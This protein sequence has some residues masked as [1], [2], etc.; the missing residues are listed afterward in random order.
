MSQ[1]LELEVGSW[2]DGGVCVARHEGRV[3][4]VSHTLPGERVLAK[5]TDQ[6]K[7]HWWADAVEVLE[8]SPD[9]REHFWPAAGPGGV[10][11]AALGHVAPA[12]ARRAKADLIRGH[13]KHLAGVAW[14]G[15]VEAVAVGEAGGAADGAEDTAEARY[16]T[17][18]RTRI[19]LHADDAGRPGMYGERS[20]RLVALDSMPL[21]VPAINGLGLFERA[22]P[23]GATLNV[24]APS[25]GEP[26]VLV[27]RPGRGRAVG[28]DVTEQVGEHRYVVAARGFWQMHV[29]APATLTEAVLQAAAP[30]PTDKVWDLYSGAGLFTLPL[31]QA[32]GPQGA[33]T[34]VE[35]N[36]L[37]VNRAST[38]IKAAGYPWARAVQAQ[39]P[40][41]V[42][43]LLEDASGAIAVLD[44]PR[45]GAG[46]AVMEALARAGIGRIC[47]VSCAPA[48]FARDLG[49]AQR[50]GYELRSLRA[51]DLFPATSHTEL[52][53]QIALPR[54]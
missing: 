28:P 26:V 47:Y 10:G 23:A 45:A 39:L 2:G 14:D 51:F 52:V 42:T 7:S 19:V 24:V 29:R 38:N 37:A 31:A 21:A 3:V 53:A 46:P 6:R 30:A 48:T 43:R 50:H 22:W 11:G 36:R 18:W 49:H 40:R 25:V 17:G 13:L 54:P 5:V 20:R 35:G 15:T 41:D 9:R 1:L 16:G 32:V 44:P 12:A 34:A 4:F 27:D 33:V 8:S